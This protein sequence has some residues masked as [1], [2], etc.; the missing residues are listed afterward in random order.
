[1]QIDSCIIHIDYLLFL[2]FGFLGLILAVEHF[3]RW[4]FHMI[5]YYHCLLILPQSKIW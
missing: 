5:K 2:Y 3:R 1:M 4:L